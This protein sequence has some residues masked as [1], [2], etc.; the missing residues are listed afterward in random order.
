MISY[1]FIRTW[2]SDIEVIID[3]EVILFEQGDETDGDEYTLCYFMDGCVEGSD[4]VK[5]IAIGE[6]EKGSDLF[7]GLID[8]ELA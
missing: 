7:V 2:G 1:K 4:E 6:Y 8:V 5:Y 3:D